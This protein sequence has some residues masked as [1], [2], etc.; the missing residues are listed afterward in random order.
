MES[1]GLF[2][3]IFLYLFVTSLFDKFGV[4]FGMSWEWF[5][6]RFGVGFGNDFGNDFVVILN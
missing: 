2:G 4:D 3:I 1:R 5:R 6:E